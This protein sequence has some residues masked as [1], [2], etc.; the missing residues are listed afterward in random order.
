[1]KR[2]IGYILIAWPIL[3]TLWIIAVAIAQEHGWK[4]VAAIVV[5][6]GIMITSAFWGAEMINK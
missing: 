6:I 1:M 2:A 4:L 5:V 3:L